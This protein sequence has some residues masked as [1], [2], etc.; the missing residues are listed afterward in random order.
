MLI[1]SCLLV[2]AGEYT[3]LVSV[4]NRY[5][6]KTQKVDVYVF[7]I[8][9]LVEIETEPKVLQAGKSA[10]FEAH[11]W[12]SPY[13]IVYT[14]DFGDNVT[15]LQGRERWVSHA[16]ARSGVYNVCVTVNNTISTT[17]T[18]TM[19]MVFEEI[20]GLKG[21][22]SGPTEF[23]TPMVIT[24]HLLA[25][26]NVTWSFDMGDG[27]VL[28]S[29]EPRI[30]HTYIKDGNYSVNITATNAVSS[31]WRVI[32]V[33]VFVLQVLWL[34]P[35]GCIQESTDVTFR[36]FVSGNAS[37]YHYGWSFG[38]GTHNE[39]LFGSPE[40]THSFSGSGEYHLS[41][42]LSS[43]VNRANFYAWVC[44]QPA[45]SSVSL[46]PLRSHVKLGE[47]SKFTAVAFPAFHYTYLW[48]F[49]TGD[50]RGPVQGAADMAFT[51]RNPGQYLV[52]VTVLNNISCSNDTIIM[53]V[54]QP[55]GPLLIMHNGTKENNLTLDQ[56]YTF[57]AHSDS[58][59][60][61]YTW[62]FGDGNVLNG[63]KVT[64]SYNRSG[65]FNVTLLGHN[66]V[67]SN[68]TTRL[69]SVLTP[70]QG[71]TVN[72]SVVNVPLNASVNFEAHLHQG[73][74]V[75]FS[76]ILCDR[77][78]SIPGSNIMYYTFRSVGTF[79]V[80]VTAS[81]DIGTAQGSILIFVQRE[82]EGLQII[83]D[84][85]GEKRCC[86]ATNQILHLHA[87][88]RE[89]TNMSFS[90]NILKEQ[91]TTPPLNYSG[92]TIDL[93]FST[94]G[95]RE[96]FLISTNLLGQLSVNK[97]IRF[98]DPVCELTLEI[99]PN[100]VAV[101]THTNMSVSVSGGTDLQYN[102]TADG[103][104]LDW[105]DSFIHH[106]F[107]SPGMK[108]VTVEV[109]NE[110]SSEII[111]KWISVQQPISGVW[112]S[113]SNVTE[114]NFVASGVNVTFRG[115]V[116]LGTNVSWTW[117]LPSGRRTGR[118]VTSYFFP[119]PGNFSV[120]LN[121][122]NDISK[123]A[124]SRDF[125]VQN[126]I[127]GLNLKTSK[128]I[129]AVGE[130]VEFTISIASGTSVNFLLSI[131]G[132][133]SVEL[134]N[135]TYLHQFTRVDPYIV[136]LTAFNQVSSER[137]SL[138]V[139]VME[140]VKELSIVN[141]CEPAIPVG[142]AKTFIANIETGKPVTFLWTFDLHYTATQKTFWSKEVTYT[143]T[144][145]GT[146][147]IFIRAFNL[148]DP[149][150]LN[151]SKTVQVQNILKS[152]TLEAQ[153]RDTFINKV[154]SFHLAVSPRNSRATFQ[155]DF[156]DG[157]DYFSTTSSLSHTYSLPGQ[158][159]VK[160][161]ASNFV[162][163]VLTEIEVNIRVLACEEPEV[164]VKQAPKLAIWR[165]QPT[166]VEANVDLKG[167]DHYRVEYLWEVLAAKDCHDDDDTKAP[168]KMALPPEVDAQRIQLSVPK[169]ALPTGNY[170]LVFSLAYEGVPLRKAACLQL[171]V[172][173]GRLVPI[174]EG[175]TYRVWSKTHDLL[176]SGEQSYD[177][178]VGLESP[179]LLSYH[180]ECESTTKV[181]SISL[182]C[183]STPY[184]LECH[185]NLIQS[186]SQFAISVSIA[187]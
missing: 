96:I 130:N 159:L 185:L 157:K 42:L 53:E 75:R 122:T 117:L 44:V 32:P 164:Q 166:L 18:C 173:S 23:N 108:Q 6:N 1:L 9:T 67:S 123:K 36:A 66:A 144:E 11:P 97:S 111:S 37:T 179:S 150:G 93:N 126:R 172:I 113:A 43:G 132:D 55:V 61:Q 112:F 86:Y 102:W 162:S 21:Q 48:D 125:I 137:K 46:Q 171:S 17:G 16:Y 116:S 139:E 87:S 101:N 52:M 45:V 28:P 182:P 31:Q 149:S 165:Y 40:I 155:W 25:G 39:T 168:T 141:C 156:G 175:G 147:I 133:A 170:T 140:P 91:E 34:E 104:L 27:K 50:S 106:S 163:W 174:I 184:A 143:P 152:A 114:Q 110:V 68:R 115:E 26:N 99:S 62:N 136:N 65:N 90:W 146:L 74:R 151:I 89:G 160:V 4:S 80:I 83:A 33:H 107:E 186:R 148:L 60:V 77:C 127:Q 57:E 71:L 81:N 13:G 85:L 177:P 88:L 153:P 3:L 84:E 14:W 59:D 98:L 118:P 58:I 142:V 35:A 103:V 54:Q 30:K 63:S 20:E 73:D 138:H 128:V 70:I 95:T 131:S 181:S 120:T 158:Y 154:V 10:E 169:M 161:N 76:W 94:P 145:P 47:E 187:F 82:L 124:L 119:E 135:M 100:P 105:F 2:F 22:S 180:W 5:E 56:G 167:C 129:A 15:R 8:L 178:N 12:P 49:G 109:S 29:M 24:A 69:L 72:A 79:N 78:T 19:M 134:Q 64:H 51:Y 92:K 7:S 183:F 38:D 176:L 121:A 41:L